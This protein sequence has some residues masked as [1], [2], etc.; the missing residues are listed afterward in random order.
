MEDKTFF[1]TCD[2]DCGATLVLTAAEHP[3]YQKLWYVN[4]L[5]NIRREVSDK[6][7]IMLY[8]SLSG[9]TP[10]FY[11]QFS[12]K[13]S[14][15]DENKVMRFANDYLPGRYELVVGPSIEGL[16]PTTYRYPVE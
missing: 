14:K 7:K 8:A 9:V 12:I 5:L 2:E 11:A 15:E 13:L 3:E 4:E 10:V 6:G 1:C 16:D